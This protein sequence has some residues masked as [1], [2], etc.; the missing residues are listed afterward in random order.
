M[1]ST[2]FNNTTRVSTTSFFTAASESV[3]RAFDPAFHGA[4]VNPDLHD[5]VPR[6]KFVDQELRLFA[7]LPVQVFIRVRPVP[8]VDHRVRVLCWPLAEEYGTAYGWPARHGMSFA[9]C[10]VDSRVGGTCGEALS[11]KYYS[12]A[13]GARAPSRAMVGALADHACAPECCII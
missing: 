6:H 12:I 5:E 1:D 8:L 9:R 10:C 7:P 2:E 4:V 13:R 11:R 3:Q